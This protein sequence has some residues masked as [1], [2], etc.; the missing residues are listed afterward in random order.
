MWMADN[1]I[2]NCCNSNNTV[3]SLHNCPVHSYFEPVLSHPPPLEMDAHVRWVPY[4]IR[5][6]PSTNTYSRPGN[7]VPLSP[8]RDSFPSALCAGCGLVPGKLLPD[9][10]T[11]LPMLTS[12]CLSTTPS[13]SPAEEDPTPP[14]PPEGA[15]T[16]SCCCSCSCCAKCSRGL[17]F[18]GKPVAPTGWRGW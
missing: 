8:V 4:A 7:T 10:A 14:P 16:C 2:P 15:P 11:C 1:E 3:K 17:W 5:P 13:P 18:G 9:S 12:S 6:N